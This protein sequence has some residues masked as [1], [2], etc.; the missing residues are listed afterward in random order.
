MKIKKKNYIACLIFGIIVI[1]F[2]IMFFVDYDNFDWKAKFAAWLF[3]INTFLGFYCIIYYINSLTKTHILKI[4]DNILIFDNK[5]YKIEDYINFKI[6]HRDNDIWVSLYISKKK[7]FKNIYF[8]INEFD[9]FLYIIKPYLK[10]SKIADNINFRELK[11]FKDGFF[12]K[13]K[14]FYYK[15]LKE[16][17]VTMIMGEYINFYKLYITLKNNK[18]YQK[19][20]LEKNNT[21][22]IISLINKAQ[23]YCKIKNEIITKDSK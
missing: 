2:Q 7:I 1:V 23:F 16:F 14:K 20:I 10:N 13:K 11:F 22:K 15:D 4:K 5:T 6:K 19:E 9:K 8:T 21:H 18:T 3:L 12:V 17:E